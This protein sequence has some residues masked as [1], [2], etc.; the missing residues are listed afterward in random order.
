MVDVT[1]LEVHLE[2]GSFSAEA[3]APFSSI[4]KYVSPDEED[5]GSSDEKRHSEEATAGTDDSDGG[6][7][8]K[9]GIVG[10]FLFLVLAAAVLRYLSGD[11]EPEVEIETPDDGPVGVTVDDE[12]N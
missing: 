10:V 3:S 9:L 6:P 12:E 8:K 2:E 7:G 11:D 4:K 5:E 1:L